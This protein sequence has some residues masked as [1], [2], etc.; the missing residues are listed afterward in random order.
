MWKYGITLA[1]KRETNFRRVAVEVK[2][3]VLF[4]I[5]ELSASL[6]ARFCVASLW[7][8]LLIKSSLSHVICVYLFHV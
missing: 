8:K 2:Q 4:G 7:Q 3:S 1:T 6:S 5:V